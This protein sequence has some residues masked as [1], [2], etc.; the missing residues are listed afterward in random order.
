M[1]EI[2]L[3]KKKCI[4]GCGKYVTKYSNKYISGHNGGDIWRVYNKTRIG[5]TRPE[6][7]GRKISKALIGITLEQR[8]GKEKADLM[9]EKARSLRINKKLPQKHKDAVKSGVLK[10][11]VGKWMLGRKVPDEVMLKRLE[12]RIKNGYMIHPSLK[13]PRKR[14]KELVNNLTTKNYNKYKSYINPNNIKRGRTTF[15]LDH[16]Y[17]VSCGF[18]NNI[19]PQ[20]IAHPV[21]LRIISNVENCTKN[22]KSNI[23]LKELYKKIDEFDN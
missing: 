8:H 11:G 14:Y 22:F 1:I 9:K 10:A 3:L 17:S 6:Y 13:E 4:C 2:N 21:N 19:L 12:T 7:I 5:E 23:T 20:V 15:H 16:I 18:K